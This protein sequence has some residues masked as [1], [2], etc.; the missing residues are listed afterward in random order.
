MEKVNDGEQTILPKDKE[1]FL[2]NL[3]EEIESTGII[4]VELEHQKEIHELAIKKYRTQ[5]D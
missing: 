5:N 1:E 2:N 4:G 3:L